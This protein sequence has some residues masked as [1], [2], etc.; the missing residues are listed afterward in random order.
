MSSHAQVQLQ[1]DT[2]YSP[3]ADIPADPVDM[4]Y[5]SPEMDHMLEPVLV[6]VIYA[7]GS[8]YM[9]PVEVTATTINS[10]NYNQA[11]TEDSYT[12][13]L[14][15]HNKWSFYFGKCR[16]TESILGYTDRSC[17]ELFCNTT[18]PLYPHGKVVIESENGIAKFYRLLHTKYTG[19]DR[20]R[21]RFSAM[22][23]GNP[24][25]VDSEEF[26]VHCKQLHA[27]KL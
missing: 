7:N 6:K 22:V 2:T 23:D 14:C 17:V 8:L 20:R 18:D 25:T 13:V 5:N 11:N 27:W 10:T 3:P 16:F 15:Q 9:D 4:I 21:L 12:G 26:D 1:L 19:S 24:L